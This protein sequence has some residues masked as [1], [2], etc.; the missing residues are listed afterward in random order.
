M[1]KIITT[2]ICTFVCAVLLSAQ[3]QKQQT[4]V[5]LVV[6]IVVE[7]MRYELLTRDWDKF[8]DSGF[9]RLIRQGTFCK[10]AIYDYAITESAP[11]YATIATGSN[12][13]MHSIVANQWYNRLYDRKYD[14]IEDQ[15]LE[16]VSS[17]F[18]RNKYSPKFMIGSTLGDELALLSYKKSKVISISMNPQAAVLTSGRLASSAYWLDNKTG[19]WASSSFYMQ[20][21]PTW[22]NTFNNKELPKIYLAKKWATLKPISDYTESLADNNSYELGFIDG[23]KV[24]PYDLY[25]LSRLEGIQIIKNTPYGNT[26]TNDFAIAALL[27]EGL[28][29]D[30]AT[31]LLTVSYSATSNINKLFSIRSIEMEDAYLRL[32]KDIAHF[33]KVLDKEIGLNNI[34]IVL[35]ADRGAS[36]HPDFLKEIGSSNGEFDS[37]RSISL[38]ESY[39]KAIYGRSRW[40]KHY[41][42]KQI[43]LNH[44]LIEKS[45]L[46]LSEMQLKAAQFLSQFDAVAQAVTADVLSKTNC[47]ND[48][49]KTF[50]N[51]FHLKHS[52]DV[53]I[54]LKPGYLEVRKHKKKNYINQSSPYRYDSHVPLIFCGWEIKHQEILRP[55]SIKDIAPTLS[56]LLNIPYPSNADGQAIYN[57]TN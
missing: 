3:T 20:K 34:I 53:I 7:Q 36:E 40:I 51:G 54:S 12:P 47:N 18:D 35:T 31:D 29:K 52:G 13:A 5:K 43:Y 19:K 56:N 45:K 32:D 44:L 1:N 30:N 38:L 39:L 22:V 6:Q 9:K 37:E 23:K 21:L 2:M 42:N 16:N 17:N 27:E 8:S 41:E 25:M 50:Q 49:I 24:F 14:C 28:G 46:S 48:N 57:L 10:N 55:V 4:K 11:G 26:Y 15:S 33:I